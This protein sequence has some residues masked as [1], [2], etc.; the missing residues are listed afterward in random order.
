MGNLKKIIAVVVTLVMLIGVVGISASADITPTIALVG[1][2]STGLTDGA[3]GYY[4]VDVVLSDADRTVGGIEGTIKYDSTKLALADVVLD[5]A[6]AV[7][8]AEGNSIDSSTAG[9]IKFVGLATGNGTWFTLKFTTVEG[10]T[11]TTVVEFASVKGANVGGTAYVEN[12]GAS[13][14]PVEIN[15]SDIVKVGGA[16]IKTV[17]SESAQDI[18]FEALVDAGALVAKYGEVTVKKIG[19]L[20]GVAQKINGEELLVGMDNSYVVDANVEYNKA[21]DFAINLNNVTA[22]LV[23][24]RILARAYIVVNDGTEDITIYSNNYDATYPVVNGCG[25]QSVLLVAKKAMKLAL[26]NEYEDRVYENEADTDY[27]GKKISE[28]ADMS[29]PKNT[30]LRNFIFKYIKDASAAGKLVKAE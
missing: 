7:D 25:N 16:A 5:S 23:G 26:D 11:G 14:R 10:A 4:E 13:N 6:F 17:A 3:A 21:E 24:V 30:E 29:I 1:M 9:I 15:D 12:L 8:N 20:M 19:A 2:S 27:N 18:K 28:L 22:N